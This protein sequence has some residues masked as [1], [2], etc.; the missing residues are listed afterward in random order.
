MINTKEDS[1]PNTE[2]FK[3]KMEIVLRDLNLYDSGELWREVGRIVS[4]ATG[5]P[6]AEDLTP[7]QS[8]CEGLKQCEQCG[9]L[10]IELDFTSV[11]ESS[12]DYQTGYI[13]CNDCE[14]EI[15]IVFDPNK[16]IYNKTDRLK[17]LWNTREQPVQSNKQALIEWIKNN[18][19]DITLE[20]FNKLVN[21]INSPCTQEDKV[22]VDRKLL[23]YVLH[24]IQKE[25]LYED[26]LEELMGK[27]EEMLF[28]NFQA[29][30]ICSEDDGTHELNI[31]RKIEKGDVATGYLELVELFESLLP[32]KEGE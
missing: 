26:K 16:E 15:S 14:H 1:K 7:V 5:L 2:Y 30:D 11:T 4:G 10:S 23:N 21:H 28:S 31:K 12:S 27:E 17:L 3:R 18:I 19:H 29:W 32:T 22:L 6:K 13:E 25:I 8:N 9:S 20:S 24:S